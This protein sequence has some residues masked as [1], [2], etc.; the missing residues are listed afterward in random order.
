MSGQVKIVITGAGGFTG[1]HACRY[2]AELGMEVTA[3]V[4][5]RQSE[6]MS[7]IQYA[8]CNLAHRREA[9]EL[10]RSCRPDYVLHL[11]GRNAVPDSWQHP[12][13]HLEANFLSTVYLLNALRELPDCRMLAVSSMLNFPLDGSPKPPHPY[14]LSKTLQLLAVQ[15]WSYLFKQSAMVA[16]PSNLIGPGRSA[17]VCGLLG[18]YAARQER[19]EQQPPFRLSTL[20]EKRDFLDV[21]D[22]VAAYAVILRKGEPG[23]VYSIGSGMMRSLGELAAEFRAHARCPLAIESGEQ[24]PQADPQPLDLA[25]I[26]ALGWRPLIT[27]EQ[28]IRDILDDCRAHPDGPDE[29]RPA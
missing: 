21:R 29:R 28:S 19:G 1:G 14:S 3:V 27:F 16:L 20:V 24:A 25:N 5:T 2:F 8:A 11:A 12:V 23:T 15:A 13:E 10:I 17:G 26:R 18:R 6:S 4:R 22:A 9:E 7:G